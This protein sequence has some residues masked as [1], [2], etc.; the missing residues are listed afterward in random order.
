MVDSLDKRRDARNRAIIDKIIREIHYREPKYPKVDW[1]ELFTVCETCPFGEYPPD[2]YSMFKAA[3]IYGGEKEIGQTVKA[4]NGAQWRYVIEDIENGDVYFEGKDRASREV[5]RRILT[6]LVKKWGDS[7]IAEVRELV[8]VLKEVLA[9]E[10]KE[11]WHEAI[12][13]RWKGRF[14]DRVIE[15]T[16]KANERG[17]KGH[18]KFA[19]QGNDK[20]VEFRG[21][22]THDQESGQNVTFTMEEQPA[23]KEWNGVFRC[24]MERDGRN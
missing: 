12:S 17:I 20:Q 23:D 9:T 5:N 24:R 4:D 14:G 8:R 3:L 1:K 16:I 7:Q 11:P 22:K 2:V 15:L 13:G 21:E 19:G 10:Y 6:Y 18:S